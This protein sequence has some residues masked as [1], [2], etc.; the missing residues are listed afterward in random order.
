MTPECSL[1]GLPECSLE[2]LMLKPKFQYF[3]HLMWRA[4]S[5]EKT[6]ML[7]KIEGRRRRGWQRMRW[8]DGITDSM[9]MTLS[10]LRELVMDRE[11]WH[12]TVHGVAKSWTWLSDWTEWVNFVPRQPR[13]SCILDSF[14]CPNYKFALRFDITPCHMK[15]WLSMFHGHRPSLPIS[16]PESWPFHHHH[17]IR[18]KWRSGKRRGVE[19]RWGTE[20]A[21]ACLEVKQLCRAPWRDPWS[22]RPPQPRP[23]PS[24]TTHVPCAQSCPTLRCFQAPLSMGFPRQQ[25]WNGLP[26]PALGDPNSRIEPTS[27]ALQVDSL[28]AGSTGKPLP[29]L[30]QLPNRPSRSDLD[31]T[32]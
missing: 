4:D 31:G 32:I 29:P 10:K 1:E 19:E 23:L 28:P 7:R 16:C 5:F 8:L 9:D 2:G 17:E 26:F 20:L 27:L 6:L 18:K 24:S 21:G 12:A 25:Y 3:G 14:P 30:M 15:T 11:T 13:T 22:L